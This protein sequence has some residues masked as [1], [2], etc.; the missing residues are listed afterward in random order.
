V[1]SYTTACINTA[2]GWGH[3]S[4]YISPANRTVAFKCM[5]IQ[6]VF[7]CFSTALVRISVACSLLRFSSSRVWKWSLYMIIGTQIITYLIF[8]IFLFGNVS[9]LRANWEPVPNAKRWDAKYYKT[10]GWVSNCK[11]DTPYAPSAELMKTSYYDV[12]RLCPS[13]HA[14][15]TNPD[16]PP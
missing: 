5:F 14:N 12:V 16:S 11:F 8:L 4:H 7:W 3:I 1:A 9:P 13:S 2:H 6:Q 10:Y 15:P